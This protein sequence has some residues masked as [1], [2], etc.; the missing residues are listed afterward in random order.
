MPESDG[1]PRTRALL[2]RQFHIELDCRHLLRREAD[3]AQEGQ[4]AWIAVQVH[5][6]TSTGSKAAST[7][8]A[9][10][11]STAF[12]SHSNARSASPRRDQ[13]EVASAGITLDTMSSRLSQPTAGSMPATSGWVIAE[14]FLRTNATHSSGVTT[15]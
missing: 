7:S 8:P 2:L 5:E 14:P 13:A 9:S 1:R 11:Y 6:F 15:A 4:P 3:L 12:S 10:L